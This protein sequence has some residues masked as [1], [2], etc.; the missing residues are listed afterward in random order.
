MTINWPTVPKTEIP[1][2]DQALDFL[3]DKVFYADMIG[4]VTRGESILAAGPAG[5]LVRTG[6]GTC[7]MASRDE[8]SAHAMLGLVN[9]DRCAC[10]VVHEDYAIGLVESRFGFDRHTRCIASAY[11]G[12]SLPQSGRTDLSVAPLTPEWADTVS[13]NYHM[14]GPDYIRT[15]I[16]AGEMWGAFH[17]DDLLGFIGLHEEGS[18]GMLTVFEQYRRQ[19]IA[20]YLMTD[21]AN[22]MIARGL[23]PHDHIIVGNLASE[24]LQRKLGFSISTRTLTWMSRGDHGPIGE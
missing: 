3:D 8:D 5:V 19:G 10:M 13:A 12:A 2:T 22:R 16:Q 7:V 9:P 17:G 24:T 20:D 21:L 14:D 11:L 23:T 15:R 6:D 1:T 4:L 18:M